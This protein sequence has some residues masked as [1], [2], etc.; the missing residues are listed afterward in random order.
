M[1]IAGFKFNDTLT[2]WP[3][4]SFQKISQVQDSN[5]SRERVGERREGLYLIAWTTNVSCDEKKKKTKP[6]IIMGTI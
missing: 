6:Y 5:T 1:D 2:E 3:K 4:L